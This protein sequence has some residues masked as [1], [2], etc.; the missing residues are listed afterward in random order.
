M[1]GEALLHSAKPPENN[2]RLGR[3]VNKSRIFP[4]STWR[5]GTVEKTLL[6]FFPD[7]AFLGL[8]NVA[9]GVYNDLP[10]ALRRNP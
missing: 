6:K 5:M 1:G 7:S 4:A 2:K 9:A 3:I 10:K 8:L